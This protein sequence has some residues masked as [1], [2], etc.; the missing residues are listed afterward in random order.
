MRLITKIL[1]ALTLISTTSLAYSVGALGFELLRDNPKSVRMKLVEKFG[2]RI[3]SMESGFLCADPELE[4]YT[5]CQEETRRLKILPGYTTLHA[6]VKAK[7]ADDP[8]WLLFIFDDRNRLVS[9]GLTYRMP[10]VERKTTRLSEKLIRRLKHRRAI[11][12][13]LRGRFGEPDEI[14]DSKRKESYWAI[15]NR[16]RWNLIYQRKLEP[17]LIYQFVTYTDA[18]TWNHLMEKVF[19]LKNRY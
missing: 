8:D 6:F 3:K 18:K 5:P 7:N 1:A 2:D 13:I 4:G 19:E 9:I 14:V 10:V 15:W 16:G 12:R 11:Y 17:S